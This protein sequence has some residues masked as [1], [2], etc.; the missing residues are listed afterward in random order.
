MAF[1]GSRR[2]FLKVAAAGAAGMALKTATGSV[3]QA[4]DANGRPPNFVVIFTDDFGWGDIGAFGHPTIRTPNLDRM[5]WEGQKWTSFYV[6]ASVCTPSRAALM[7]GRYPIRSGMCSD[8]RRVLFPNSNGGL[9]QSELTIAGALKEADYA[10]ACIGKWH[11]GHLPEFLPTEHGFDY[12]YGIPYSNDMDADPPEGMNHRESVLEPESE[13]F[14]VPLMRDEETIERPAD[15]TTITKRFTEE[16]VD[17]IR[18]HQDEPF[19]VYLAHNMPHVPL[20]RS[21]E[22]EDVSRAGRYGDVIE[23]VDWSVGQVMETLEELDL[24]ENTLVLFT[25]DNGPWSLLRAYMLHAGL[26]GPLRGGKGTTWEGGVRV[27]TVFWWPGT[28]EPGTVMEMGATMDMLPTFAALA[29][30]SLPDDRVYDGHDLSPVLLGE[31]SSPRDSLI[32]YRGEQIYAARKGSY[33][34]HFITQGAYGSGEPREEHDRPL[35]YNLDIDP[36][37]REDMGDEH[38]EIIAEIEEMVERHKEGV[39]P[40]ENQL[41]K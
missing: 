12:Y 21:E 10:T 24:A 34:A 2:D 18:E 36:P 40:V 32:Y 3:A 11:L 29:G 30:V 37:E 13:H 27:P 35:L 33:K 17:F 15:Q 20:F 23:E 31:G 5:I 39:E 4:Q 26:P 19:F 41:T 8:D 14:N 9:P 7:T 6:G 16:T 28:V 38:P 25:S 22:F 1:T